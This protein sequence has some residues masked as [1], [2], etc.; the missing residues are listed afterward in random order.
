MEELVELESHP[1]A[2]AP[3]HG[4]MYFSQLK[5]KKKKLK[6]PFLSENNMEAQL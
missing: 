6:L 5:I 3:Q 1:Q 2:V 4:I